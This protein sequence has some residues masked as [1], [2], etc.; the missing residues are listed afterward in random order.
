MVDF[1]EIL[2]LGPECR[3]SFLTQQDI[4]ELKS[5]E[6]KIAGISRLKPPYVV[7]RK[8]PDIHTL[9]FTV[10]GEGILTTASDRQTI[11]PN[12]LAILRARQPYRFEI[13]TDSWDMGWMLLNP[14]PEW[15]LFDNAEQEVRPCFQS[16]PIY[17]LFS[18]LHHEIEGAAVARQNVLNQI[19]SY[20][21]SALLENRENRRIRQLELFYT[22][23]DEQL[24]YPWTVNALAK[25]IYC[26][27][28]HLH[29]LC[30][31]AFGR[32]PMQQLTWLRMEKAKQL[33]LQTEWSIQEIASRIGYADAF[34]FSTRFKKSVG[35]APSHYRVLK[36]ALP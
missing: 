25:K 17:H 4:P 36:G 34:N 26:S 14:M 22:H 8:D 11:G 12:T 5:Q 35:V 20:L 24:H 15:S 7:A 27:V 29:R 28:P 9:L 18:I 3:E 6:I 32:G 2:T 21:N 19:I 10:R 30:Q 13:S 31:Q 23:L 1:E 16:V 33:L